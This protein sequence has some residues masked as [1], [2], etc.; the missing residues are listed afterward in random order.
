ML[1]ILHPFGFF[2]H[3]PAS[4]TAEISCIPLHCSVQQDLSTFPGGI[5]FLLCVPDLKPI[6]ISGEG[7]VDCGSGPWALVQVSVM[8]LPQVQESLLKRDS[9][10][11]T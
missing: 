1:V 11:R 5:P 8:P 2:G 10:G 7:S 9:R 6:Q 4:P 3:F